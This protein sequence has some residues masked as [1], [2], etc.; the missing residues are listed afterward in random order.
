MLTETW[1]LEALP[2][3]LLARIDQHMIALL[4][5]AVH[6]H[7]VIRRQ[8]ATPETIEVHADVCAAVAP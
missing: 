1:H 5:T 2:D 6:S 7:K 4:T 8:A 3:D